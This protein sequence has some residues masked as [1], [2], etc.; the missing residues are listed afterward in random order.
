M[1]LLLG[2][3][4]EL[5][6][7]RRLRAS[8][9][10][11]GSTL[12]V[13][14][15][16]GIGRTALLTEIARADDAQVLS[17]RGRRAE[18]DLPF[19][20]LADLVQPLRTQI[21]ALPPTQRSALEQAL[22]LANGAGALNPYAVGT[23]THT[24]FDAAGARR[25]L[26]VLVDDVERADEASIRTLMFALRRLPAG[27]ATV[28]WAG[29]DV[30]RLD[31]E[32]AGWART[33]LRPLRRVE[34][35]RVLAH[36][37]FDVA[38]RVLDA[39]FDAGGGNPAALLAAVATLGP[40]QRSGHES[41]PPVLPVGER[42]AAAWTE[43]LAPLDAAAR[44]ALTLVAACRR[45]L[46]EVLDAAL[47]EA[48]LDL[49]DLDVAEWAGL[50][51]V[52]PDARY[53]LSDPVLRGVLL[54]AV[55]QAT[56]RAAYRALAAVSSGPERAWYRD[57]EAGPGS[58]AA[59]QFVRTIVRALNSGD[60]WLAA[61][62]A[63]QTVPR[64]RTDPRLRADLE[65]SLGR[66]YGCLGLLER[67][68]ATLVEAADT[69][70][71]V[72]PQRADALL[73]EALLPATLNGDVNGA[74]RITGQLTRPAEG[75]LRL[76]STHPT[77]LTCDVF[78]VDDLLL[79]PPVCPEPATRL[80][81]ARS[82]VYAER[83]GDARTVL[84]R[85]GEPTPVTLP[86]LLLTRAELDRW[87]GRWASARAAAVQAGRAAEDLGQRHV[88]GAASAFLAY[89][90]AACG[91]E[92]RLAA[93]VEN[94]QA[95]FADADAGLADVVLSAALGLDALARGDAGTAASHLDAAHDRALEGGITN[96]S[97]VPYA[98]DRV[99]AHLRA[100]DRTAAEKALEWLA[101][102]ADVSG[103]EWQSAAAARCTG[104]LA[105][106]LAEAEEQFARAER[107]HRRTDTPYE[108]ARTLLAA[109]EALRRFR[110][111]AAAREPLLAAERLFRTL[112]AVPWAR[113]A[114]TESAATG[115][116]ASS[117]GGRESSERLTP[118]EIEVATAVA[119]GAT[120]A[121]AAGALYLSPKTV[122]A[123]LSHTYR[124]LGVRSRVDLALRLARDGC[125]E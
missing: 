100:G 28:V 66:A 23:A 64:T 107:H 17:A 22:A 42:L 1:T 15:P 120:N 109:G 62:W 111:P 40:A 91:R 108:L 43:R 76:H 48:G 105:G 65:L 92:E 53:E 87:N 81:L 67:A 93:H 85:P 27:R 38:D 10:R 61:R 110:R 112:S 30:A 21:D 98:A 73:V 39:L 115:A 123:H 44:T 68:Q 41:L 47:A 77:T 89:V 50:L 6:M 24:L 119:R 33:V 97:V 83:F 102:V 94:A 74:L 37:G 2:R 71:P 11:Y 57:R 86:A 117:S 72:D 104:M 88:V 31:A 63:E 26:L 106:T 55:P 124:K 79:G 121:E 118:Q 114:A 25:S 54:H 14:G 58:P 122:E 34:A 59:E 9:E 113:R 82:C 56:R 90:E 84:D 70:R 78:A 36:R 69:V 80:V 101:G 12:V 75:L 96:P 8:P 49:A 125:L 52:A 19:A 51:R 29:R 35:R 4:S 13:A 46:V 60:A 18:S 103:R 116:R 45:P 95:A 20:V 99:E 7:L 16:P 32:R 5:G 3:E